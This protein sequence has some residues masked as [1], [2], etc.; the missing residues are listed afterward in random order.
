MDPMRK[1]ELTRAHADEMIDHSRAEAP[2]ECCGILAGSDTRVDRVYR[3]NNVDK[4]PVKY[5][6]DP[7]DMSRIFREADEAGMSVL[8]FYHSHTFSEAYPSVTDIKLAP[9]SDW[10]EF[11]YVIVSLANPADPVLRAFRIADEQVK[12]AAL[13]VAG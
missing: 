11:I 1:L 10:F 6:I 4:S 2:N 12:D 3:A 5:T 8:G 7:T 13:E 9:P